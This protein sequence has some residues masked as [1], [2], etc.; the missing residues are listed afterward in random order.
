MPSLPQGGVV[1]DASG[2]ILGLMLWGW[3]VMPF[4]E[5]GVPGVKKVLMAK[6]LNK[7]PDGSF[8]Q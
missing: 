7:K 1:H 6:F 3:L 4:L 2:L 8:L 5:N